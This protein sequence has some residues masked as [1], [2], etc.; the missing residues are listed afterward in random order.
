MPGE[1]VENHSAKH[2]DKRQSINCDACF[3]R[4]FTIDPMLEKNKR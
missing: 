2:A 1:S 4:T 3:P